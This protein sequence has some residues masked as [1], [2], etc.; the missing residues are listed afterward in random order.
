MSGMVKGCKTPAMGSPSLQDDLGLSVSRVLNPRTRG[1]P[2]DIAG[3]WGAVAAADWFLADWASR[4]PCEN[5][6]YETW[7]ELRESQC[8]HLGCV[9]PRFHIAGRLPCQEEKGNNR[10]GRK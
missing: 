7:P 10:E 4:P 3:G 1:P 2:R 9:S 6:G 8:T 5:N